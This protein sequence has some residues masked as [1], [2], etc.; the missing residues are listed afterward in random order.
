M[1][2]QYN[3]NMIIKNKIKKTKSKTKGPRC[4]SVGGLWLQTTE[5]D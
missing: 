1:Y 3:N 5:T 4:S 2:P